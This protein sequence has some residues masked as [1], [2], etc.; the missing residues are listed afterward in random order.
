MNGRDQTRSA[1]PSALSLVLILG[2]IVSLPV[3]P[4]AAREMVIEFEHDGDPVYRILP[5]GE[6]PAI[7]DP[8]FVAGTAAEVQMAAEEPVL[9]LEIDGDARAYSLWQLDRHE[10]VNDEIGGV[11]LAATW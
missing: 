5:P 11:A 6:I 1:Y 9:G 7:E 8:G 3:A 2:T 4:T 10:I